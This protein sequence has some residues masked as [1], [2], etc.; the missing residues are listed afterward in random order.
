MT[1]IVVAANPPVLEQAV[2]DSG[3]QDVVSVVPQRIADTRAAETYPVHVVPSLSDLPALAVV[4]AAHPGATAVLALQEEAMVAAGFLRDLLDV[5]G[6]RLGE[7]VRFTDKAVMKRRLDRAGLPVARHIRVR[8]LD[9]VAAAA[10]Q[11]GWPVV[12]KPVTGGATQHVW[13]LTDRAELDRLRGGGHLTGEG[14]FLVEEYVD[15][16]QE[17]HCEALFARGAEVYAHVGRYPQPLLHGLGD[18]NGTTF[19]PDDSHEAR[20]VAELHRS[21][22]RTLGLTDGFTHGEFFGTRQGL[23]VGEVAARPGGAGI[24]RALQLQYGIDVRGWAI[25]LALDRPLRPAGPPSDGVVTWLALAARPGRIARISSAEE[26]LAHDGVIEAVLRYQPGDMFDRPRAATA[27]AGHVYLASRRIA[28]AAADI[29]GLLA[30]YRF[31]IEVDDAT[32]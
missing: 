21:A 10:D 9:E 28:D 4:A 16:V 12:S 8:T 22:A 14:P 6:P 32:H 17:Y 26:L 31:E 19:L 13:R 27:Y 1:V 24:P 11:L 7:A 30:R 15:V 18:T 3:V 2:L 23:L 20:T 5:P 29:A 25:D